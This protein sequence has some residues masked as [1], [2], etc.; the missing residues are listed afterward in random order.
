MFASFVCAL[1]S[2]C[3]REFHVKS[4]T[5]EPGK[6]IVECTSYIY[7]KQTNPRSHWL[8]HEKIHSSIYIPN[9]AFDETWWKFNNNKN[10]A[11][12]WDINF[13]DKRIISLCQK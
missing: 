8:I 9:N 2:F 12:F 4:E 1:L 5:R 6:I 11:K 3:A 13:T 10:S 7:T